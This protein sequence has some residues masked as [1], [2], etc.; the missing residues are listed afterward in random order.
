M[1]FSKMLMSMVTVGLLSASVSNAEVINKPLFKPA[2]KPVLAGKLTLKLKPNLKAKDLGWSGEFC[3][4]SKCYKEF[5]KLRFNKA[6]CKF[7][8]R[9]VN[10]GPIRAGRFRV[11][12]QYRDW[13]GTPRQTSVVVFAGLK[14][15][16]QFGYS[17][18][19][20]FNVPYYQLGQQFKVTVDSVNQVRESNESDNVSYFRA[21]H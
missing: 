4:M 7:S 10:L 19:V 18:I 16:G 17:K 21:T 8:V 9:V 15:K 13:K 2:I 20:K 11:K 5:A 3:N 14:A 6:T 1:K 12:L